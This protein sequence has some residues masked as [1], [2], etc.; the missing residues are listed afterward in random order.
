MT[1]LGQNRDVNEV[2]TWINISKGLTAIDDLRNL[3]KDYNSITDYP[4]VIYYDKLYQA[5][6]DAKFIL[7]TRDPA[8]WEISMK[9]TILQSISDIQHIPNPDEWW[10][11]MIDWFN[12]EMLARYH[13]GKLYTDTQGEIIAH[14][15]RVIQT[16]PADKLLIYEVGQGW[17]P[18][19]KF[20]GV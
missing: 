15:Q 18:L 1:V 5:Y 7:T 13:Q 10:T 6:P 3:L 9:N 2:K 11:S 8:K 12:N 20:L 16:I 4:A 19:V 17:D 14:N